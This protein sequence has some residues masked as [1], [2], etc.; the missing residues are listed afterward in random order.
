MPN[1]A[2]ASGLIGG[3]FDTI[4]AERDR[5]DKNTLDA[6][7]FLVDTGRVRDFNELLPM[8]DSLFQS[9]LQSLGAQKRGAGGAGG[10]GGMDPRQVLARFINPAL[11]MGR[12]GP[13]GQGQPP[14]QPQAPG[15]Q[16]I[17]GQAKP[18]FAQA[19]VPTQAAQPTPTATPA[20]R[21]P[22]LFSE[23]EAQARA[24][25][26]ATR[27]D[28]RKL[29]L[30]NAQ[31]QSEQERQIAV[32][33][34][35]TRG[36]VGPVGKPLLATDL[37][38][39][40]A[41]NLVDR[42]GNPIDVTSAP[43]WQ[44]V[45][46]PHGDLYYIPASAAAVTGAAGGKGLASMPWFGA[47]PTAAKERVVDQLLSKGVR[48]DQAT[49]AQVNDAMR[50]AGQAGLKKE[51]LA[52]QQVVVRI[53]K[54]MQDAGL[55][56]SGSKQ[57]AEA[58]TA[59][60]PDPKTANVP[61][62]QLGGM[63]PNAVFSDAQT[64]ALTNKMPSLG[65]G[66][67][68]V[69]SRKRTAIDNKAAALI[70]ATGVDKPVLQAA[71]KAHEKALADVVPFYTMTAGL[72]ESTKRN[73]DLAQEY[74]R[75]VPRTGSKL[76]NRYAQWA[77]QELSPAVKL[78]QFEIAV[79][80]AVREYAKVT[81]GAALSKAG[82]TDTATH[83]AGELLS[84]A[85]SPE[86]FTARVN[87]MKREMDNIVNAYGKKVTDISK[88]IGQFL[89]ATTAAAPPQ[90]EDWQLDPKTGKFVKAPGPK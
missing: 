69:Q 76:V 4:R 68:A 35:R 58:V 52:N 11:E 34:A 54:A 90:I 82:L 13:T 43:A 53:D 79:Y 40:P 61:D 39:Q 81:S 66:S 46:S 64:Y 60:R 21:Q 3:F 42:Q 29:T 32:E 6:A 37:S 59:E 86:A 51:S 22:L 12:A 44:A 77:Q 48:P 89:G 33:Q 45:R 63:T 19:A 10:K 26:A 27:A 71:Y 57:I 67:N 85:Q 72:S 74:S 20:G 73:L 78:S 50:A 30:F 88:T 1:A 15:A 25:A 62:E 55:S 80:A 14:G 28:Q 87:A 31:Q 23:D 5:R 36:T 84:V 56:A 47:L 16:T 18:S 17:G 65:L 8:M 49:E 75:S 83:A 9:P 24:E 41:E 7:R 2:F 38:G 70:A